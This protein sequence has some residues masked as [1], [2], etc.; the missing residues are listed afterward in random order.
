MNSI[1]FGKDM[2]KGTEGCAYSDIISFFSSICYIFRASSSLLISPPYPSTK[3][4]EFIPCEAKTQKIKI[5]DHCKCNV[6]AS[7]NAEQAFST[8]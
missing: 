8:Q 6:R 5:I 3:T 1:V 7:K 2:R 4:I